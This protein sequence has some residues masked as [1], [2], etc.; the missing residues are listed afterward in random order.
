[1]QRFE[2]NAVFSATPTVLRSRQLALLLIGL[3]AMS[4]FG[5]KWV[6]MRSPV[7]DIE[8]RTLEMCPARLAAHGKRLPLIV[9]CREHPVSISPH[10]ELRGCVS[11]SDLVNVLS[12]AVPVW[13]PPTVAAL[14]HELKLWGRDASFPSELLGG[15][16]RSS[17]SIIGALLSDK[18]CR[19]LVANGDAGS[20]LLDSPYGVRVTRSGS[21]DAVN[22][23]AEGH[24]GQ[25]LKA[26]A[27]AGV[28]STTPVTTASGQMAS[29]SEL[30]QDALL[31]YSPSQE[32]EFIACALARWLPPQRSWAN[33]FDEQVSFDDVMQEL[34]EIPQGKGAC[35]GSHVAFAIVTL[36]RVEET[37]PI[38]SRPLQQK[39]QQRL[40][41]VSRI[42]EQRELPEGG[43][44]KSWSAEFQVNHITGD[45]WQDF[46]TVTGHHLEWIALAPRAL[47][48]AEPVVRR[49]T[50]ALVREVSALTQVPSR[51]YK[52]ELPAAHAARAL[53]W[54]SGADPFETIL[55][56]W[57]VGE[58]RIHQ[59]F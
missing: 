2:L 42:L 40:A 46:I 45:N 21:L 18:V 58:L 6:S 50:A 26:L 15:H 14:I 48:P 56:A 29:V 19:S 36:L 57:K 44:D 10:L 54:L 35:G 3:V 38:L 9:Q 13:R 11:H 55:T 22:H 28:P 34:L 12:A 8:Q 59:E 37:F 5:F 32:Q 39:G 17:D 20:Y 30:F 52:T 16:E 49:A 51:S 24:F 23:L 7:T 43:W 1:M 27:E 33:E 4:V 53:C 25:L 41:G 47:R 31:T